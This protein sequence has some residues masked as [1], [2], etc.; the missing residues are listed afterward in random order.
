MTQ[1]L[2]TSSFRMTCMAGLVVCIIDA[3]RLLQILNVA[4]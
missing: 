3:F 2:P 1:L 4:V